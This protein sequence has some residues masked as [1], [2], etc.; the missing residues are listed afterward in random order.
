M[1]LT[2]RENFRSPAS[3][4]AATRLRPT[5]VAPCDSRRASEVRS[6]TRVAAAAPREIGDSGSHEIYQFGVFRGKSLNLLVQTLQRA[7]ARVPHRTNTYS[8][9]VLVLVLV[10][11]CV[12]V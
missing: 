8:S 6:L 11:V 9:T 2:L 5:R 3:A 12:C 10:C 4:S 7:A 1:F